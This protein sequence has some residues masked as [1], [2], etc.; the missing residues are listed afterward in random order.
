MIR[1]FFCFNVPS[2]SLA[3][4]MA[5]VAVET[6]VFESSVS[7]FIFLAAV[8]AYRKQVFKNVPT[9]AASAAIACASFTCPRI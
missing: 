3:A 9:V 4:L 5:I 1:T 2:A 8:I 7:V 6:A